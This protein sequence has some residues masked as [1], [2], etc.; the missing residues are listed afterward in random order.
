ML[1]FN[2]K[3][4][5]DC[6]L[7]QLACSAVHEEVFN[8]R[9]ARLFVTSFYRE[10][11]LVIEGKVC[12]LCG[13]CVDTCPSGALYSDRGYISYNLDLCTD[14]GSC[15]EA[16]PQE[17]ITKRERGIALCDLCLG[18]PKCVQW[19]PHEAITYEVVS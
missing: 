15:I 13:V 14:C 9:R 6:K 12:N 3:K 7:C 10:N 17:V 5:I 16:C 4:C 2:K 8:P 1:K 19:C 18:K 11:D